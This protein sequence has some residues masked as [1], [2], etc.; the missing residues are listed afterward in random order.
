MDSANLW[1]LAAA[2]TVTTILF[3]LKGLLDQLP[4]LAKSWKQAKRAFRGDEPSG[5]DSDEA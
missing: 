1:I 4:D 3:V 5:N 2:G